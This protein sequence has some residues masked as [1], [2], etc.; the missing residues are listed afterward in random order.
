VYRHDVFVSY[1]RNTH[2]AEFIKYLA[3]ELDGLMKSSRPQG[4][5]VFLDVRDR[6]YGADWPNRLASELSAS[7]LFMPVLWNEYFYG[8]DTWCKAEMSQMLTRRQQVAAGRSA[9]E[10]IFPVLVLPTD[11]PSTMSTFEYLDIQR[12]ANPH[13]RPQTNAAAKLWNRLRAFSEDLIAAA[14]AAPPYDPGW[15]ELAT[16]EFRSLFEQRAV[17]QSR[18]LG[19]G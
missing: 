15:E 7:R 2:W 17:S 11:I 13:I 12:I 19:V 3:D 16:D 18:L 9:P 14:D 5:G 6:R 8:D 10:I 1:R 4:G